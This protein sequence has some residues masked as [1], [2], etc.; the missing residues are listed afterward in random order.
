MSQYSTFF[1]QL[2]I[3]QKAGVVYIDLLE[4]GPSSI[5]SIVSRTGLHRPEVY[6]FLPL[7]IEN[8]LVSKVKHKKRYSYTAQSPK[9]LKQ[10]LEEN[11]TQSQN[12]VDHL[13]DVYKLREK[14]P[15][16]TFRE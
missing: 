15:E 14:K 11:K 1:T 8:V 5:A 16:V 4:N 12:I 10:L 6:R 2:G 3:P 9:R 7:L 13:E